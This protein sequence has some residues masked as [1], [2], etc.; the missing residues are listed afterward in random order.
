VEEKLTKNGYSLLNKKTEEKGQGETEEG[1]NKGQEAQ[2]Q[3][4]DF[5]EA[6][7]NELENF[8]SDREKKYYAREVE[9]CTKVHD[10]C[11]I[12]RI[13]FILIDIT[14][15]GEQNTGDNTPNQRQNEKAGASPASQ[16]SEANALTQ[17]EN[18][19]RSA[20]TEEQNA[21][22]KP[23]NLKLTIIE[24]KATRHTRSYHY[25]QLAQYHYILERG[26]SPLKKYLE[27]RLG[28][29]SENITFEYRLVYADLGAQEISGLFEEPPR[30]SPIGRFKPETFQI[31]KEDLPRLLAEEGPLMRVKKEWEEKRE[32]L[33]KRP[34]VL[35]SRCDYCPVNI[36]CLLKALLESVCFIT[37]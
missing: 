14:K 17:S 31:T 5:V 9:I 6:L 10:F 32:E 12:G 30:E 21:S 20:S 18:P 25:L 24:V 26:A 33:L 34:Y 29:P 2:I 13:D 1:V 15:V 37:T 3:W 4:E 28:L 11:L 16:N 7:K 35:N 27:Q 23:I 19:S 22:K 36:P 8:G